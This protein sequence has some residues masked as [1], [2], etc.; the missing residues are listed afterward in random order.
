[1]ALVIEDGSIVPGADS[2]VTVSQFRDYA[3]A[4]GVTVPV[5][6][7]DCEILLIKAMDWLNQIRRWKGSRVSAEQPL[8]WPRKGAHIDGFEIADDSI[9]SLLKYAQMAAGIE[10]ISGEIIQNRTGRGAVSSETVGPIS[11]SYAT[12]TGSAPVG[13]SALSKPWALVSGLIQ[14][15]GMMAIRS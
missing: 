10:S 11:V 9:P 14:S 15:S 13:P 1:M 7:G 12:A 4:R 3:S 5:A 2:Y 8:A 6:D